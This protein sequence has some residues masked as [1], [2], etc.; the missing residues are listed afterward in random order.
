MG[1]IT[2]PAGRV[3]QFDAPP[4]SSS[5]CNYCCCNFR[6]QPIV[7]VYGIYCSVECRNDA[8]NWLAEEE[9]MNELSND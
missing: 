5:K 9:E 1:Q 3:V 2:T 4:K 8:E 6:G 7:E